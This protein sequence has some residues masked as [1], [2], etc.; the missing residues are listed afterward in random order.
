MPTVTVT[1]PQEGRWQIAAL[2]ALAEMGAGSSGGTALLAALSIGLILASTGQALAFKRSGYIL[3]PFFVL[4]TVAL[5]FVVVLVAMASAVRTLSGGFLVSSWA[6]VRRFLAIGVL[7]AV[8]GFCILFSNPHVA[9]SSQALLALK[10]HGGPQF[11]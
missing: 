11:R 10:Q 5:S 3:P 7:N 9:G 1:A 8:N 4:L 6:I 2:A